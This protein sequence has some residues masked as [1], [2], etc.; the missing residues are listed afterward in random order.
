MLNILLIYVHKNSIYFT[1][2]LKNCS[3]KIVAYLISSEM[4]HLITVEKETNFN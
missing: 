2:S 4:Q 3:I 1:L